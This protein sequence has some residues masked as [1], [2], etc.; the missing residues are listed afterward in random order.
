MRHLVTGDEMRLLDKN[1]I[2]YFGVP[3]T[4]LIEQ[5]A[6]SFVK[7]FMDISNGKLKKGIV[8]CGSGNNGADGIAIARLLNDRNIDTKICMVKDILSNSP[9]YL[10]EEYDFVIDGI[11]GTGLSRNLSEE[12]I[13]LVDNI[14]AMQGIKFAIDIPSGIN[15]DNGQIMS[16]AVKCDYTI[17][18][19]FEK[20]GLFLW[21]GI[22]YVGKCILTQIGITEKSWLETKPTLAYL[23]ETDLYNLP[24]RP[25]HSNKG[26]FGKLLIIAG[27]KNMAGAAILSAKAAYRCGTGLVK[28]FTVEQNR[29]IVQSSIPEAILQTYDDVLDKDSLLDSIKWADA[30]VIGPGLG[31]SLVVEEL[32]SII[33]EYASVPVVWDADALNVLAK[34]MEKYDF[35]HK[36]YIF[37]PH[38]GEFSR[39]TGESI[40]QIQR[41]IIAFSDAFARKY[42]VVCVLKD[43]H[44]VISNPGGLNFLNLSGNNGMATA[45]SGDVLAGIIGSLLAQGM[46]INQGA[47]MGVY[48]H[49]LAGDYARENM[50]THGIMAS[51]I[52]DGLKY[53]WKKVDEN[54][55]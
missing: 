3:E 38:L 54:A 42:G 52:I 25:A 11:F 20:R 23:E 39:L 30:I 8:F 17:T 47:S 16:A 35:S 46:L 1:T 45:G 48:I 33:N 14:N 18:F 31:T 15:S 36:K 53:L 44:T 41:D 34:Q 2:E 49:G 50:G 6:M 43:F 7:E 27:S 5:A 9:C 19:S 26:T 4:L 12:Y 32:I 51:D 13:S 37:T 24:K 29:M 28:I 22:D 55:K 10:N 21:P 40:E